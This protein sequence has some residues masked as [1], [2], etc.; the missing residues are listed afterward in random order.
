MTFDSFNDWI[1]KMRFP[2]FSA[3]T[4][5]KIF[6]RWLQIQTISFCQTLF[7]RKICPQNKIDIPNLLNIEFSNPS[8]INNSQK[9]YL[10]ILSI[11]TIASPSSLSFPL[12]VSQNYWKHYY[13]SWKLRWRF[14][15]KTKESKNK[16]I[17]ISARFRTCGL[18][19][20]IITYHN[21]FHDPKS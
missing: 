9:S 10:Y 8:D 3:K 6:P 2:K 7:R 15:K 18:L 12:S 16:Y 14:Q 11:K 17:H 20:T 19:Y 5:W 21:T 1:N 13:K 4:K